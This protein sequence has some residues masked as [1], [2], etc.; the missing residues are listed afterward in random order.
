M[1]YRIFTLQL[2]DLLDENSKLQSLGMNI[3]F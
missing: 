2:L 1:Y 3:N